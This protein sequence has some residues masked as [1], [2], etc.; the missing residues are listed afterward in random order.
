MLNKISINLLLKLDK[1]SNFRVNLDKSLKRRN[2]CMF[3]FS[4]I[5]G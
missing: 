1:D 3:W 5:L 2:I 4:F